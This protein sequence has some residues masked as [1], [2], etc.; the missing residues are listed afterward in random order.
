[1]DH[2]ADF[3]YLLIRITSKQAMNHLITED[4]TFR[5]ENDATIEY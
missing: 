5:L 3:A 2:I 1:M 4:G